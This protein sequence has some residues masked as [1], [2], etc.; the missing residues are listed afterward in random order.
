M[1]VARG[2]VVAPAGRAPHEPVACGPL[3]LEV[4][5]GDWLTIRGGNGAGKS[6]LLATL[7]GLVPPVAGTVR[8]AGHDPSSPGGRRAARA[9]VGV[10]FQEPE[11]QGLTGEVAREIAFPLEN[12]GWPRAAIDARVEE[13]IVLLGL[14]GVRAAPPAHL[15]GGEA[16]RVALAAAMAA[17]PGLLL[18]DEPDSYLDPAGRQS[19]RAALTTLRQREGTTVVWSSCDSDRPAEGH[20]L[21]L[22][23]GLP[24]GISGTAPAPAPAPA[25]VPGGPPLWRA[26]ELRLERSD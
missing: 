23:P 3:D 10:V 17:G 15:S 11:T 25:P 12:L 14:A 2:L 7:A 4:H 20:V 16:Q 21:D 8:I 1:L 22:G 9:A 6:T 24:F 5:A 26:H 13:L 19:L 18:L